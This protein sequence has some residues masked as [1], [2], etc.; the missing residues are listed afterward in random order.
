M[1]TTL[2][3]HPPALQVPEMRELFPPEEKKGGAPSEA[4]GQCN[5]TTVITNAKVILVSNVILFK[6]T[7]YTLDC[8]TV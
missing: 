3:G 2:Q 1:L 8:M 4:S 6:G 7:Y 5:K